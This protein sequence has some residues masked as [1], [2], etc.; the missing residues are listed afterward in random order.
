M[1]S[2]F[3]T[4]SSILAVVSTASAFPQFAKKA[5][6]P[7]GYDTR[8]LSLDDLRKS[9]IVDRDEVQSAEKRD[10]IGSIFQ[11]LSGILVSC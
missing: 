8:D 9:G 1:R 7:F 3:L 11:P 5:A 10:L 6:C 2:S 4:V